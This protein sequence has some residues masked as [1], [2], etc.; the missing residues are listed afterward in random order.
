M[1]AK[2]KELM[3]R[4]S[5]LLEILVGFL[6]LAALFSA[7]FGLFSI[8]SPFDLFK[9]PTVFSQYLGIAST[10][11]IGVEF[12]KMLCTH[13]IDSVI[14]IMLLAIA[15]QMITEHT[16]PLENLFAVASIAI[17]Y[18][19]RKF[20]YIRE[21]DKINHVKILDFLNRRKDDS[22]KGEHNGTSK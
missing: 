22:K 19:V 18:L 6:M 3:H 15:R 2:I 14:D 21:L 17:L 7:L 9:D 11:V 4:L 10:I 8:V 13:T 12:V 5:Y 1:E 16:S 20:L